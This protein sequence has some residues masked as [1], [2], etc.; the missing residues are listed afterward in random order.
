ME[1]MRTLRSPKC[2]NSISSVNFFF[3]YFWPRNV[4]I[5]SSFV[6][7]NTNLYMGVINGFVFFL[8]KFIFHMK[9]WTVTFCGIFWFGICFEFES[10]PP[11]SSIIT[12]IPLTV[13]SESKDYMDVRKLLFSSWQSALFHS[14]KCT[15]TLEWAV[16]DKF[17]VQFSTNDLISLE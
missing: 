11:D 17:Y 14:S 3:V 12:L 10:T 8:S 7:R 9:S 16:N 13:N 5:Q 15:F 1:L 6:T 4:L 2:P